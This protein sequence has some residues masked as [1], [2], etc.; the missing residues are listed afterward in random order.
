M[1]TNNRKTREEKMESATLVT[2]QFGPA[3]LKITSKRSNRIVD[4]KL[5]S[6][7]ETIWQ[8]IKNT[9]KIKGQ[10]CYNGTLYR[11]NTISIKPEISEQRERE[12]ER[13]LATAITVGI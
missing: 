12:R 11:L 5:E 8:R 13:E 4:H 6:Q 1:Q 7:I 3:D 2:G 9:A 10:R